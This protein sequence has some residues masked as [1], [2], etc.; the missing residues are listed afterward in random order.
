MTMTAC[1]RIPL[2][3]MFVAVSFISSENETVMF[4]NVD[5]PLVDGVELVTVGGTVSTMRKAHADASL[6]A[7]SVA[8]TRMT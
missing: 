2:T 8:L 6:P 5:I 3:V 1:R 4:A 7:S